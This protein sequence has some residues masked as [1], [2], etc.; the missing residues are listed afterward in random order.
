M[1]CVYVQMLNVD[2]SR[3]S[4]VMWGLRDLHD[5]FHSV[6]LV[7]ASLFGFM[8]KTFSYSAP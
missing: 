6:L 4:E 3:N 8:Q 7:N 2:C 5:I 1:F